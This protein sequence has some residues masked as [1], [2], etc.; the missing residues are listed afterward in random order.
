MP[1]S[2]K[3]SD[4]EKFFVNRCVGKSISDCVE[5]MIGALF[6]SSSNPSRELKSGETGLYRVFRWLDDIKCV[7]LKSSGILDKVKDIKT[8]SLDL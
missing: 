6:L 3:S 8:S 1:L 4:L 5:A 2:R 7:P